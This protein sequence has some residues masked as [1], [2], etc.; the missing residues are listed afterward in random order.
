MREMD[1]VF[2]IPGQTMPG[3]GETIQATAYQFD[4]AGQKSM[5]SRM[6]LSVARIFI[7][8]YAITSITISTESIIHTIK[9][10]VTAP[11]VISLSALKGHAACFSLYR[12]I[13]DMIRTRLSW[14]ACYC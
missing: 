1:S 5:E 9:N 10:R 3:N 6:S 4:E 11:S 12:L 13:R 14:P 7:K 2:L 8:C